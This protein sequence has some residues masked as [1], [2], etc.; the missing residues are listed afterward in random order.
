MLKLEVS[1]RMWTTDGRSCSTR[2]TVVSWLPLEVAR[3]GDGVA[4]GLTVAVAV[5]EA[6]ADVED[7]LSLEL[8]QAAVTSPTLRARATK[9]ATNRA[10]TPSPFQPSIYT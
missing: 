8:L 2:S 6:L 4:A 10:L 9:A 3:A 7:E 5:A 1:L